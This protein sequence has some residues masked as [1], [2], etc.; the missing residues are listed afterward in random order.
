VVVRALAAVALVQIIMFAF[1]NVPNSMIALNADP[2]PKD[3]QK[4]SYFL[5]NVCGD[6]TNRLCPGDGVGH[7]QD[8][9]AYV[10]ADGQVVVPQ[11]SHFHDR[12]IVPFDRGDPGGDQ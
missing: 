9:S 7:H 2:W 5:N 3:L 6:G 11:G 8:R 4:R 1:Y 12:R 10:G